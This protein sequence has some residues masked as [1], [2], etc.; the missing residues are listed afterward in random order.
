M[1]EYLT[2][3]VFVE[4]TSARSRAIVGVATATTAF[5]G[6]AGSGGVETPVELGSTADFIAQF[7]SSPTPLQEAVQGFF[8]AGGRRAVGLR[9]RPSRASLKRALAA[10]AATDTALVVLSPPAPGAD[11]PAWAWA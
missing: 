4:E 3:G 2:P 6:A 1:P 9:V 5:I 7:G 11:V 8:D 10:L